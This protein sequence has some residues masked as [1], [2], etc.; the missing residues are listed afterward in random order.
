MG[1]FL[2]SVLTGLI[3]GQEAPQAEPWVE[4]AV[5]G[6][7][8]LIVL[9]FFVKGLGAKG[10]AVERAVPPQPE[11]SSTQKTEEEREAEAQRVFEIPHVLM[12]ESGPSGRPKVKILRTQDDATPTTREKSN[13]AE[14]IESSGAVESHESH[15]SRHESRH[16][17]R[18]D[19]R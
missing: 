3:V 7:M 18:Q 12:G 10:K 13:S 5:Y 6:G 14:P 4:Y 11:A 15:E 17:S 8:G 9:F 19:T 2:E 1:D 16:D